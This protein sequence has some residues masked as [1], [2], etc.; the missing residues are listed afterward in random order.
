M[1][2]RARDAQMG[3]AGGCGGGAA[4]PLH[5]LHAD[6]VG[7][8]RMSSRKSRRE[9]GGACYL[10]VERLSPVWRVRC[11]RSYG[12]GMRPARQEVG[13]VK[14]RAMKQRQRRYSSLQ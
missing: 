1:T 13:A 2:R 5:V 6:E 8:E 4:A 3:R 10:P 7:M 11:G 12:E 14:A 9:R